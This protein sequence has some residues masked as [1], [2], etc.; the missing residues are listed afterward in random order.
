MYREAE[1][2]RRMQDELTR[3]AADL[4]DMREEVER[5]PEA[6][7]A[8]ARQID[9]ALD[10]LSRSRVGERLGLAAEYFEMGSPLFVIGQEGRVENALLD[11]QGRLDRAAGRMEGA[12]A[13]A[14]AGT[15]VDDVQRLR[16]Q[17]QAIGQ[18][19]AI[20]EISEIADAAQRMAR[21]LRDDVGT[22]DLAATRARYRGLGARE[23][24]RERLYQMTLAE[25]DRLEIA[26]GKVEGATIRA[27]PPRDSGYESAAVARYFR[28]LSCDDC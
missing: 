8:T 16:R 23:S 12:R 24:N 13:A 2:K 25:L 18:A 5:V 19:G 9:R 20:G 26:L 4:A 10:E 6:G 1:T 7:P 14:D 21:D 27:A 15:T 17:L 28:Q 11:F 3:I 22:L